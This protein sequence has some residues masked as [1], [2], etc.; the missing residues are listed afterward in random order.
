MVN[1]TVWR[2]NSKFSSTFIAT[3][4]IEF[5]ISLAGTALNFDGLISLK[6]D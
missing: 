5:A 3:A 6:F 4:A 2:S 1:K